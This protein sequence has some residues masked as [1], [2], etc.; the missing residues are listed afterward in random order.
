[1]TTLKLRRKLITQFEDII[2]DDDKLVALEGVLDALV[3]N[4]TTSIIPE[5]HYNI[6]K[7]SRVNYLSGDIKGMD[8][9]EAKQNLISKYGL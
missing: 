1:M 3:A 2:K 7:E 4:D 5:E 8:W 6:I 9:E